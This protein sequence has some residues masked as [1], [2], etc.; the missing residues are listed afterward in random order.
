VG[1][2]VFVGVGEGD[3]DCANAISGEKIKQAKA[4]KQKESLNM[5]VQQL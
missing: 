3:A 1:K 4:M 2:I 5:M